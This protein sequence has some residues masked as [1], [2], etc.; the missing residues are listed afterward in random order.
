MAYVENAT[1][2][3]LKIIIGYGLF[4]LVLFFSFLDKR[5]VGEC[6]QTKTSNPY[7]NI[8]LTRMYV[9]ERSNG[10]VLYTM[11][12]HGFLEFSNSEEYALRFREECK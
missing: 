10:H 11:T 9:Q 7:E 4:L 3:T 6:Y 12:P 5:N 2:D 8:I 1:G